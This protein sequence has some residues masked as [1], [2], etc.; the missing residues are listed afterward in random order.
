MPELRSKSFVYFSK[1]ISYIVIC[2]DQFD[3]L[4]AYSYC[5]WASFLYNDLIHKSKY[6]YKLA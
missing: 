5:L 3:S 4:T 2:V 6:K 1:I